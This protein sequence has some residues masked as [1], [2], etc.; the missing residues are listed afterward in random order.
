MQIKYV[1]STSRIESG[2]N[3][4]LSCAIRKSV[5]TTDQVI[6]RE[7]N[8]V[9]TFTQLQTIVVI[10]VDNLEIRDN[11]LFC[12]ENFCPE[13]TVKAAHET[14]VYQETS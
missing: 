13:C 9:D 1:K 11:I 6:V 5:G 2:E 14:N 7:E 10:D 3:K 8:R 12:E 4:I